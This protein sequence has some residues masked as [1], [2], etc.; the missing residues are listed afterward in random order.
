MTA[1]ATPLPRWRLNLLRLA[2]LIMGA[3]LAVTV[4][5]A[6]LDPGTSWSVTGG[7]VKAMLGALSL[8]ALLGLFHPLQMLPVL[9]FEVT[10]KLIWLARI[11]L[12]QWLAGPL[13][14]DMAQ[15]AFEVSLIAP[16]MLLIPWDQVW[17]RLVRAES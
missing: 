6:L 4:W 17:K 16:F 1:A 13:S 3:G 15:S 10:W 8:L 11:A 2:Y 14:P 9:L 5:P 12:P 7:A